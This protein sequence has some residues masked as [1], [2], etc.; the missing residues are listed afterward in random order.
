M[1][2]WSNQNVPSVTASILTGSRAVV[3]S[4]FQDNRFLT[5]ASYPSS[6][7]F[8]SNT[9]YTKIII[10]LEMDCQGL[11]CTKWVEFVLSV[12]SHSTQFRSLF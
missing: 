8:S 5:K 12:F 3:S 11:S 2:I 10:Y 7:H 4:F 9:G 6:G 1:S